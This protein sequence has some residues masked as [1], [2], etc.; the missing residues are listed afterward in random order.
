ML[1]RTRSELL[2]RDFDLLVAEQDRETVY[3]HRKEVLQRSAA[4]QCELRL[5][6]ADGPPFW[7]RLQ[8]MV[9]QGSG[10]ET[11]FLTALTDITEAKRLQAQLSLADR[12]ASMGLLAAGVAHE[13]NNPLTYILY[14]LQNVTEELSR[15][16]A[17]LARMFAQHEPRQLASLGGPAGMEVLAE[18]ASEA[19][20]GVQR[21][22]SISRALGAF[23]R[24][25]E[26]DR[27]PVNLRH[28]IEDACTMARNEIKY[29]A[30]LV[31]DL[32][33]TPAVCASHGMLC[34]V[35]LNL[36]VNA[37]H[38][39]DEGEAE[40]NAIRV[41]T[42]VDADH[43]VAEVGD[44]GKGIPAQHHDQIFEPFF[45]TKPIGSGAGLGLSISKKIVADFGGTI[46][47]ETQER[48]G[49]TF[50]IR[51][52]IAHGDE[53]EQGGLPLK[54]PRASPKRSAV[55]SSRWMTS[56]PS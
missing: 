38:A 10:E 4:G 39:I 20:D 33:T 49:T 14:N 9:V 45:S 47:F 42:Y 6:R 26:A 54:I 37:A 41:R 13:I 29:R 28:V 56:P 34:Q 25:E 15:W 40:H 35:F 31:V 12:L 17:A 36:L 44:T 11:I 18:R 55:V 43:V 21:I 22:R 48:L 46:S 5:L 7:A 24:V 1:G 52:P 50:R 32:P 2:K 8:S 19:L 30:R 3:L 23:S 16:H 27:V 53:A 51:L